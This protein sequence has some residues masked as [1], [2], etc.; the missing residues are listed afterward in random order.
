MRLRWTEL[1]SR[2]L[3][4]I[5]DYIEEHDSSATA[6]R[7]SLAIVERLGN[8]VDFPE[9]GRVG[10]KPGTR[11]LVFTGL[12]YFAVYRLRENTVEVLRILHGTRDWR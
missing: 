4:Q 8:L 6:R 3:T 10:R 7:V 11:E 1:A 9:S 5:C 2:D 12:P